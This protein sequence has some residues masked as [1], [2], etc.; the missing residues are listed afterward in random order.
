MLEHTLVAALSFLSYIQV[1]F[2]VIT[3]LLGLL[4]CLAVPEIAAW[5]DTVLHVLDRLS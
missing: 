2:R 5:R 1:F 3:L 4:L